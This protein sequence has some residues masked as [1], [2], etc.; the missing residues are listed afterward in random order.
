MAGIYIHI[1]LCA[2]K[3]AYCDFYSLPQKKVSADVLVDSLINEYNHRKPELTGENISTL[4]I[5]GG[6]PSLL[7][8]ESM[9]RLTEAI[10]TSGLEEFTVEVNPEDIY[11]EY[12]KAIINMGVKRVSMGVQSLIDNELAFIG[13]RHSAKR[14]IDAFRTLRDCGITNISLDLIYGLPGQTHESWLNSLIGCLSLEPEH[15]SAYMLSY[16]PGTRLSAMLSKGKIKETDE[17]ALSNMYSALCEETS[18]RG[19]EHYEIS[20]FSRP[21]M[22]SRH[23]SSY[24]DGSQYLGIGPGAHSFTSGM[25]RHNPPNLSNYLN[26]RGTGLT[27]D[28]PESANERFNDLII[29][30][31]RTAKGMNLQQLAG[32]G[33][34]DKVM[35]AA[36][37]YLGSG[38]MVIENDRLRITEEAW[39]V[40][41]AIMMDFIE[42]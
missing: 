28:E 32:N 21:G 26:A 36:R 16:E 19:Y 34:L 5:G 10:G 41:D 40:A 23:N 3:C 17:D 27:V 13:R 11:D 8:L 22:H 37:P 38:Q 31:L 25:R 15:L 9:R 42:V 18:R 14:A 35:A 7:P 4:Y 12:V 30:S 1:P 29:T 39:L 2:S 33:S 24:W 6:T 20:N